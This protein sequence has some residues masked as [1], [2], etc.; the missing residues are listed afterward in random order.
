[1]NVTFTQVVQSWDKWDWMGIALSIFWLGFI[2]CFFSW[3][4]RKL[5]EEKK[6]EG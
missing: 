6:N 4:H 1:M 5:E 3:V 2:Y